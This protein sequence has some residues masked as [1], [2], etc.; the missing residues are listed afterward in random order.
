MNRI[1]LL[2]TVSALSAC[3]FT[4]TPTEFGDVTLGDGDI[5]LNDSGNNTSD[6]AHNSLTP[7]ELALRSGNI[8]NVSATDISEA[9]QERI[10]A[11]QVQSANVREQLFGELQGTLTWDPSHDAS[12][13]ASTPGAN[14]PVLYSND[15]ASGS[16]IQ[17]TL[18][19]AGIKGTTPYLVFG[20]NP[21]R[22]WEQGSTYTNETLWDFM[23][24]S[25]QWLT[26]QPVSSLKNV[27][28]SHLD[29]SYYFRDYPRTV[30]WL[31]E[32]TNNA[33][34][35]NDYRACDDSALASCLNEAT[36]L[37]ILSQAH[38]NNTQAVI[39][40]I[41][42]AFALDIPILYVHWNGHMTELG[43]DV[44]NELAVHFKADN[45]WSKHKITDLPIADL[46]QDASPVLSQM[47]GLVRA[48]ETGLWAF[49]L[50]QCDADCRNTGAYQSQFLAPTTSAR[51][52]LA[53]LDKAKQPLFDR[54]GFELDKLMALLADAYRKE[55]QFPLD[56]S[57][58]DAN[59]FLRTYFADHVQYLNREFSSIPGELGNFGRTEFSGT[60]RVSKTLTLKAGSP[61]RAAGVYAFPGEGFTVTRLDN[62]PMAIKVFVNTQRTGATHEFDNNGYTR[63][64]YLR[65]TSFSLT[66]G[67]SITLAAPVGGPVQIEFSQN[68]GEVTLQFEN[69]GLHPYWNG[70][71]DDQ[72]FA[73]ALFANEF[74]WAEIATPG[75]EVH[76]QKV[77]MDETVARNPLWPDAA[78]LA[79]AAMRFTHNYPH[80]VAGFEGAGIDRIAE[81]SDFIEGKGLSLSELTGLKHM[82]ADQATCGYGCSGNPYDAYWSYNPIGHGDIHELGHGLEKSRFRFNT[83]NGSRWETHAT[84]N[85]YSYY[86]KSRYATETGQDHSCQNLPFDSLYE[87][88]QTAQTSGDPF[89]AMADNNLTGWNT[90]VATYIQF[91]MAAQAS[92]ALDNGWH[93]WGRLHAIE[94]AFSAAVK[95]DDTWLEKRDALGFSNYSRSEAAAIDNND[96]MLISLSVAAGRDYRA[97]LNLYGIAVS[98]TA[99]NQLDSLNYAQLPALF[100]G[101]DGN[102]YCDGLDK[103]VLPL[104]GTSSWPNAAPLEKAAPLTTVNYSTSGAA[105][106]TDLSNHPFWM[107]SCEEHDH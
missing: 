69:I 82:N 48:L 39:S 86:S 72:T 44:F 89:T 84:T 22:R 105:E 78:S 106:S 92:G 50:N 102:N 11:Q 64:K 26:K 31:N 107:G 80:I 27:V 40:G 62:D 47:S 60:E 25:V 91:M 55:F 70:P 58:S 83:A 32:K 97:L 81:I 46:T 77:K 71:E 24:Q 99:L 36:D 43:A 74:D 15:S 94:R 54:E 35:Y 1:A 2:M 8:E 75:F 3:S 53:S 73:A 65:T 51:D 68:S 67:E 19:V 45:Y 14:F 96:W 63:P 87:K 9:I 20:S 56:A 57:T 12:I 5:D 29:D 95:S 17:K 88:L 61:F 66:A 6:G 7:L 85:V 49:D 59:L 104:D 16:T 10:D 34:S 21:F 98:A 93:L 101:A 38:S 42:R 13:I 23:E 90:G 103:P 4:F 30:S 37:L 76:S 100:Y 28:I 18:A 33:V 79:Q 41:E 52:R